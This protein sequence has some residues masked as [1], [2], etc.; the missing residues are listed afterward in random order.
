MED[1]KKT[2]DFISER[3]KKELEKEKSELDEYMK[4][5]GIPFEL[6][7]RYKKLDYSIKDET[8]AGK[9]SKVLYKADRRITKW[10]EYIERYYKKGRG[11]V[12]G[13]AIIARIEEEQTFILKG[14]PNGLPEDELTE[15]KLQKY[16]PR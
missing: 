8:I 1:K 16:L 10:G 2:E 5:Y 15:D 11:K 7:R 3:T 14:N 9:N 6:K 13:K 12:L 4:D